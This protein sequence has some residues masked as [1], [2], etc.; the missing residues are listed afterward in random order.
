MTGLGARLRAWRLAHEPP[1]TLKAVAGEQL[2]V[3]LVSKIERDLVT[4]S[5]STL[6]YLAGRLQVPLA[7]LFEDEPSSR[8]ARGDLAAARARLLLGDPAAAAAASAIAGALPGETGA[9]VG[10]APALGARL[11]AVAAEALLA[12]GRS[13]EASREVETASALLAAGASGGPR[14]ATLERD[15]ATAEVAWVLGQLERRRA[16]L[17]DATR[18]WTGC[19][20]RLETCD[21]IGPWPPYLRAAVLAE[22]GAVHEAAGEL[23]TAA[24]LVAR[25]A[26]MA[27]GVA[28]AVASAQALLDR[29]SSSTVVRERGDA[30][31]RPLPSEPPGASDDEPAAPAASLALAVTAAADRLARRL[32]VEAARLERA[33][34]L[35]RPPGGFPEASHSRHLR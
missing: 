3:A 28:Q 24:T 33:A 20:A 31:G 23:E 2:S 35:P 15:L 10:L 30:G 29:W 14:A 1:L 19:L 11:R 22:L 32:T 8:R 16:A 25:A 9:R 21:A 7:S 4:P 34:S 13:G 17:D 6:T 27:A 5:L 12:M 26:T 18:T